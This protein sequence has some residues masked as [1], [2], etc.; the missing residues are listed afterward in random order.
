MNTYTYTFSLSGTEAEL[1]Q[2]YNEN[3]G[4]IPKEL[5]RC[6]RDLLLVLHA[7]NGSIYMKTTLPGLETFE[8]RLAPI[9][10]G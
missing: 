3:E 8:V 10:N 6:H 4:K 2:R 5:L 7:F 9:A 1:D